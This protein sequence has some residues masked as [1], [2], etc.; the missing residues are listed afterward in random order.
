MQA[1]TTHQSALDA[2]DT[3]VGKTYTALGVARALEATPLVLCPKSVITPWKRVA[4]EMGG[5]P[6]DVLNIEKLK[7][8]NTKYL[9]KVGKNKWV[10]NLPRGSL[11]IYD[12]VQTASGHKS[13]NGKILGLCKA[14]GIKALMLSAT[15][16]ESP[17]K[18]KAIGYM[19]GLHKYVDHFSW[20]LKYGCWQNSWGGLEFIKGKQRLG[21]LRRIHEQIFPDKGCR[22]KIQDLDVFPE[23]TV[24]A[25]AFD[26]DERSTEEIRRVYE[27][28]DEE[29]A[30]P[31]AGASELTA[32]LRARQ[33]TELLKVPL[34]IE[35][36]DGVLEEERSAVVFV[37]FTETLE[38]LQENF[39]DASSVF[40]G[41]KQ[42]DRDSEIERFQAD[43]T[44]VCLVMIQAGGVGLSL[45]DL[46]GDYPR[47][48]IISPPFNAV[49]VKQAL[50]R[51]HRAGAKTK[52]VQ[53][54]IFAA[55][56]VEEDACKAVRRKL[57]NMSML[58]DGDLSMSI[59]E[60]KGDRDGEEE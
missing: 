32:Q 18:L 13:Q 10:W 22:V 24:Y 11:L 44:R 49:Q 47:T 2:S 43:I 35:L 41:Q 14:Y 60:T 37:N 53:R 42:V 21:Y 15:V 57:D 40:G 34:L 12:E 45:H 28:M 19:L 52:C 16:A 58:N 1:L 27:E 38:K 50:G 6:V 36:I 29:L 55:N 8:G 56:T 33:R 7:A 59:F 30:K 20:C 51:I 31:D 5:T 25:D 48:S 9:K 17:L 4:S 46:H 54:I 26:L 23:N 3:G 39:K